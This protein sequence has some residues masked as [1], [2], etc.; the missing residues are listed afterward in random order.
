VGPDPFWRDVAYG[1][2]I[3]DTGYFHVV[4]RQ[5]EMRRR[6]ARLFDYVED[7]QLSGEAPARSRPTTPSPSPSLHR[8]GSSASVDNASSS[9]NLRGSTESMHGVT[10]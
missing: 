9:L 4:E 10:P 1:A 7:S 3:A 6:L 5:T 8:R 2:P